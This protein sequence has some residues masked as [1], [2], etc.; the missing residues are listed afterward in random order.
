MAT[1]VAIFLKGKRNMTSFAGIAEQMNIC[2]I[3]AHSLPRFY[4]R[5]GIS[6]QFN[7]IHNPKTKEMEVSV[8]FSELNEPT[9]EHYSILL[10]EILDA[11][12]LMTNEYIFNNAPKYENLKQL[13]FKHREDTM[14]I[15]ERYKKE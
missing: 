13:I 1:K 15:I 5:T 7:F 8:G 11:E 9:E 4:K 3:M 12:K 6:A 2:K 14:Q 10:E